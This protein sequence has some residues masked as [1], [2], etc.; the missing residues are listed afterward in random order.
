MEHLPENPD[1]MKMLKRDLARRRR[2]KRGMTKDKGEAIRRKTC[3]HVGKEYYREG[4]PNGG[5]EEEDDGSD[6]LRRK[7]DVLRWMLCLASR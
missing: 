2:G 3:A 7:R 4:Y 5:E 6:V 1:Y